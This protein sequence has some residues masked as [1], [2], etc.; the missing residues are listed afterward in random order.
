MTASFEALCYLLD[1]ELERQ[2]N[3]LT[4]CRAQGE[5]ARNHDVEYLEARTAALTPLLQEAAQAEVLRS[6]LL[7]QI[8]SETGLSNRRPPLSELIPLAEEPWSSR[9]RYFQTRFQETLSAT[10]DIVRANAGVLRVSLRVIT[11]AMN[12]LEQCAMAEGAAYT[13]A[14]AGPA[15]GNVQPAVI[16]RRG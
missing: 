10:R 16:D 5:S 2:E 11:Q 13:A 4:L 8:A 1:D 12:T 7:S 3:I 9:L 15:E 14:G 6:R